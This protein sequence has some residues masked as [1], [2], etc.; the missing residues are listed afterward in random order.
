MVRGGNPERANL[1][2]VRF[3]KHRQSARRRRARRET[4]RMPPELEPFQED[5]THEH[6]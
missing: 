5:T 3:V 6:T 1:S 2:T 4:A